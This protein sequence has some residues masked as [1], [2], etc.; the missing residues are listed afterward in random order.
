MPHT[1]EREQ[2]K[3]TRKIN[4]ALVALILLVSMPAFSA[5]PMQFSTGIREPLSNMQ[6]T[7]FND[8]ITKEVFRRVGYDVDIL[9]LPAARALKDLNDGITDGDLVR[10]KKISTIFP[11]IRVV[12]EK[13]IDFD[14]VAIS[15]GSDYQPSGWE[16]LK[17]YEVGIVSGWKILEVNVKD[18]VSRTK[19]ED[20]KQLIKI[21]DH[22][23]VDLVVSERW[24]AMQAISDLGKNSFQ[25]H[26]PP[27]KSNEMFMVVNKKHEQLIPDLAAAIKAM[28]KDGT[29]ERIYKETLGRI[30]M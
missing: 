29:F 21:L 18:T 24:Q 11:N 10:I 14:F 5:D 8:Q 17:P 20:T 16:S 30:T 15:K 23:R 1:I 25:I 2:M 13:I 19:V 12:P 7:G 27:I 4:T 9:R 26:E 28:K 3:H 22:D 6:F